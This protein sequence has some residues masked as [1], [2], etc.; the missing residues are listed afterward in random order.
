VFNT[1]FNNISA[2][3]F[4]LNITIYMYDIRY[5]MQASIKV[6]N[7]YFL[8]NNLFILYTNTHW[9]CLLY[10]CSKCHLWMNWIDV[11]LDGDFLNEKLRP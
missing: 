8:C 7:N 10:Q 1:I 6:I 2:I 3:P 4:L 9:L 11:V 5:V